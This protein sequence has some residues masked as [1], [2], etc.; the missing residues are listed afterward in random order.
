MIHI[1]TLIAFLFGDREA[2][3]AVANG[4]R[5]IWLGLLFVLSAGFAREYD[6]EDLVHEPWHV[7]LPLGAS[8]LTSFVLFL[9]L[10]VSCLPRGPSASNSQTPLWKRYRAFLGLYWMTA[11]LAWLYAMPVERFLDSATAVGVNLSLL[12]LVSL[13]RVVLMTKIVTVVYSRSAAAAFFVVMFFADTVVVCVML[14][15]PLPIINVMGGVALSAGHILIAQVKLLVTALALLTWLIWLGGALIAAVRG[16]R[17]GAGWVDVLQP[18]EPTRVSRGMWGL[19]VAAIL[20]WIPI[21]PFTQ[22]K[23]VNKHIAENELRA[24]RF[25]EAFAYMSARQIDDFPP[26]WD[27]PPDPGFGERVPS[28]L[29]VFLAAEAAEEIAPWVRE[30]YREKLHQQGHADA[31]D[32]MSHA[33]RLQDVDDAGLTQYVQLLEENSYG[34]RMAEYHRYEIEDMLNPTRSNYVEAEERRELLQRILDLLPEEL[35]E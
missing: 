29:E 30:I 14:F 10:T 17:E 22:T 32:Y 13:W 11:P 7:L 33:L 24:G 8:L 28:L 18:E 27:P 1:R 35:N 26:H 23:Q 3:L 25:D 21:L 4:R 34:E 15:T 5:V 2:I 12:G 19:A 31:Y 16:S 9:L 6:V 20:V